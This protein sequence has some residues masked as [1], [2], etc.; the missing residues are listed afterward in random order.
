MSRNCKKANSTAK[1]TSEKKVGITAI[2][3]TFNEEHNIE[4]CLRSIQWA[5]EL[6]VVDSYSEDNTVMISKKMGATVL[7]R[8]Y[9][10][11]ADQK[12]WAIPRAKNPW[13]I[14]LDADEVAEASMQNEIKELLSGELEHSAFWI[15]RKNYFLG[16][17]VRFCG[18]QNDKV[19][20]FFKRD[21]HWYE[22]KMVHAEIKKNCSVGKL[23]SKIHHFTSENLNKYNKKIERY[24]EYAAKQNILKNKKINWFHLYLKPSYKFLH[25][26]ILRG[27]F[28]DGKIGLIICQFRA[29]ETWLKAYKT[30]QLKIFRE[31]KEI[32]I[33]AVITWVD[34]GDAAHMDKVFKFIPKSDRELRK[35]FK[36]RFNEVE[37]I[38][39]VVHSILKYAPFIR[40]IFIVTDNQVP[41]FMKKDTS[42]L[43][44]KVKIIDHKDIFKKDASFLPVFNSRSIETKLYEIPGLSK[45]FIYFNDDMFL[46]KPLKQSHF[47]NEGLPIIRGKWKKFKEDIFYKKK[48]SKKHLTKPKHGLA[49][50]L[51]AKLI[52]FKKV[53]RFQHT[54]IPIRKKILKEFFEQNRKLEITNIKHKF[55]DKEQFLIQGIANHIEIENNSCITLEDYQL[56]NIT[57]YKRSVIW[58]YLKLNII[59]NKKNKL[60][61][62][63]QE[64]NLYKEAN[65]KFVLDWLE[66]KYKL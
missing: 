29:K 45:H 12:N 2:V 61:L 1:S 31:G 38:K 22:N 5:D 59:A 43:Y 55:R 48:I 20:R 44:E 10:Y 35:K 33:D 64:L 57:S 25:S 9:N 13:V 16:K 49:Q 26:Y 23:K 54:P 46:L 47:F 11:A 32:P 63:I 58:L 27:G 40:E 62:N 15:R 17:W 66:N 3:T 7:Q 36:D 39:F 53:F 14:L 19:I 51:S 28:L 52:G 42:G 6:L 41:K 30:K 56:V 8:K 21:L 18:W 50:D 60:F 34:N 24:A 4:R 37:E 65:K